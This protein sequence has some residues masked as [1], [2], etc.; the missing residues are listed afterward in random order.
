[1]NTVFWLFVIANKDIDFVMRNILQSKQ[2]QLQS[3]TAVKKKIR[4]NEFT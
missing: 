2:K 3:L 1:M 4:V